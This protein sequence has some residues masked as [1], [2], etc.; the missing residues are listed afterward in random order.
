MEYLSLLY[1]SFNLNPSIR[2]QIGLKMSNITSEQE[3]FI[4][5]SSTSE[6]G[7]QEF[8]DVLDGRNIQSKKHGR[9]LHKVSRKIIHDSLSHSS[10][11][12]II[13]KSLAEFF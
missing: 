3:L 1:Y 4:K 8:I 10:N 9:K 7:G 5:T 12:R 11:D 13:K 6:Q 2:R